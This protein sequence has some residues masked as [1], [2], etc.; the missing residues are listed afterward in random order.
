MYLERDLFSSVQFARKGTGFSWKSWLPDVLLCAV[1]LYISPP[2][3][4]SRDKRK[5]RQF[6][7][8]EKSEKLD[9]LDK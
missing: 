5:E 4:R 7:N 3:L 1:N 2:H 9:F 8:N 6:H